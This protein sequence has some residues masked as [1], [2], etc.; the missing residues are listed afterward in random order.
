MTAYII[1]YEYSI[2]YQVCNSK[3]KKN[4]KSTCTLCNYIFA[5]LSDYMYCTTLA[6]NRE[7]DESIEVAHDNSN[8]HY[9]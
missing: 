4:L 3:Y 7:K 8:S 5:G 6:L 2:R 1:M 9:W